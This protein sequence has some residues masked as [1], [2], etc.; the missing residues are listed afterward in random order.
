MPAG[1]DFVLL[2]FMLVGDTVGSV[3]ASGWLTSRVS[4]TDSSAHGRLTGEPQWVASVG[5]RTFEESVSRE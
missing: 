5:V 3:F 2:A 4:A 1:P